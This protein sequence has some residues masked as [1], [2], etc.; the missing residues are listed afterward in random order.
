MRSNR[1]TQFRPL[2]RNLA[3]RAD[4]DYASA[5]LVMQ[6]LCAMALLVPAFRN[7]RVVIRSLAFGASLALLVL[8]PSR[9]RRRHPAA[10]LAVAAILILVLSLFHPTTNSLLSAAAQVAMYIAVLAP[11]FWVPRLDIDERMLRRAMHLIWLFSITSA[12]VGLLQV[13]F[14][15]TFEPPVSTVLAKQPTYLAGLKIQLA[16][17]ERVY[18]PMGLTDIPGGAAGA[19]MTAVLFGTWI[20][21]SSQKGVL[22][23][24]AICGV[25]VG[26]VCLFL[27]QVRVLLVMTAISFLILA[28]VLARRGQV[29]RL[30][31]VATLLG[32]LVAGSFF[33]AMVIA[34]DATLQRL[35]TLTE[36]NFTSVYYKNRG[37][38]LEH[39]FTT[40]LPMY[41]FGIGPGRWGMMFAYF[42]DASNTENG[43]VHAEI[44]WTGWLLDGGVPLMAAYAI[45]L[46]VALIVSLRTAT[47]RRDRGGL[48]VEAAVLTGYNVGSIAVTFSYSLFVSQAGLEF[49]L[50]N[51]LLYSASRRA[52]QSMAV[53]LIKRPG[54][55]VRP[56]S[57]N[58]RAA[59]S[60]SPVGP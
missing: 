25:V 44:M 54:A 60:G 34:P 17:G 2:A 18:R 33:W 13:Y 35:R 12:A 55:V 32:L 36:D 50:F 31:G 48:W 3:V 51:A 9:R 24:L 28:G 14:P 4:R 16:S 38:F 23:A 39:T 8:I 57:A 15:G 52:A 30:S 1:V 22:K 47:N 43:L 49:W 41:P 27:C 46:I 53:G 21:L 10:W 5:L 26:M 40:L 19:G 29:A 6:W 20:M 45:A 37:H 58:T 56:R 7:A 42:G 59:R 11:L